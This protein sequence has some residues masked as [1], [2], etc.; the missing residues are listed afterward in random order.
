MAVE[1]KYPPLKTVEEIKKWC[2]RQER[3]HSEVRSK[4]K[5]WGV[6]AEET[7]LIIA[8]L[9]AGNY[10]NEERFARAF[11]R[12]KSRMNRWGWQKIKYALKA[13]GIS[14]YCIEQA[15]AEIEPTEARDALHN[16]LS[17][18]HKSI[19]GKGLKSMEVKA[20]L[21]RFAYAKGYGADEIQK[22]LELLL[23]DGD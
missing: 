1:R 23:G 16:L 8:D 6:F 7:E 10:L 5:A 12:G 15:F 18:K 22:T 17:R 4:L 20:R 2:D 19:S 9:I 21:Y 14:A 13:K 11:A 3:C